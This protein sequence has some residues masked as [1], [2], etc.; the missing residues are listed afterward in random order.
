[1]E[2]KRKKLL[3]QF[4]CLFVFR[5]FFTTPAVFGKFDF[6]RRVDF[7]AFGHVIGGFAHGT[8]HS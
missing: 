3:I 1:M 5:V 8:H 7:I 2:K 6:F 4:V